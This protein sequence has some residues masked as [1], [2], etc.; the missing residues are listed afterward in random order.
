MH[1]RRSQQ[2]LNK[3]N[4]V[5]WLDRLNDWHLMHIAHLAAKDFL[6]ATAC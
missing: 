1:H 5:F 2:G 3:K 6:L 4:S